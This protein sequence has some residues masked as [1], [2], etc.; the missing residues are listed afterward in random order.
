MHKTVNVEYESPH[1]RVKRIAS[2]VLAETDRI[3][4]AS[5]V[6]LAIVYKIKK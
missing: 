6:A 2:R 5:V 1:Y 4:V 3:A